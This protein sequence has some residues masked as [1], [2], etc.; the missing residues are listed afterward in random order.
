MIVNTCLVIWKPQTRFDKQVEFHFNYLLI[1]FMFRLQFNK[2][3]I[4][5][6][7]YEIGYFI[8]RSLPSSIRSQRSS[9]LQ[10]PWWECRSWFSSE[11]GSH[12][13]FYLQRCM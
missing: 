6:V 8:F 11:F 5:S 13:G 12:L 10:H 2:H 7:F 4:T 9:D 3:S 1:S